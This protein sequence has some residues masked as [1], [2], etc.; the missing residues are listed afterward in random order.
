MANFFHTHTHSEFSCLDA[1]SSVDSLVARAKKYKQPAM[2][3]TDHGN[4]AG[5]VQLYRAGQKYG[6]PVFPG[7]EGYL[8]DD[9]LDK[10]AK[11]YHIGLLAPTFDAYQALS[12]LSSL[13]HTRE[14][15]Q[16]FPRFDLSDLAALSEAPG[17]KDLIVLTGCYFGMVQQTLVERGVKAAKRV[18]EMYA[19][20]FPNTFVEIQNHNIQHGL[21]SS[22]LKAL[23]ND[24]EICDAMVSIADEV[25]LPVIATQ[26]AHYC[27]SRDKSAHALMKRMVYMSKD[28]ESDNEFPGDS[29][30]FA[31][32][33]WMEEHHLADHWKKSEEGAQTMLDLWDLEFPALDT[34]KAQIPSRFKNPERVVRDGC[35]ERLYELESDGLL[36]KP[37]KK[38]E[39]RLDH[40]FDIIG[41]LKQW[42]YFTIWLPLVNFARQEGICIEA[43]GSSNGSLVNYLLGIT[44][45]D[46]LE[47]DLLFERFM[48]KDRKKPPDIDMDVED[49]A[50]EKIVQFLT[51]QYHA[52]QIGTF[53]DLGAREYDEET[54]KGD[55]KGSVLV[56]YNAYLRRK[57]GNDEFRMQFGR[58]IETI[59]DVVRV[60]VRDYK[61]LRQLAKSNVKRSYGVH[62]AGLLLDGNEVKIAD[63]VPTMLVASSGTSVTQFTMDDVE[64]LGFTKMDILGQRTLT[65]LRRCQE[66]IGRPDPTDFSWIPRDDPR[67][68]RTLREGRPENA[69]F[70][71]EGWSMAKGAKALG[72]RSTKDCILAGALFRPACMESG[73][74]D[75]YIERRR[76]RSLMKEVKYPHPVF[77]KVLKPTNG[78][79][80]F[81]EQV[82]EIM[83]GLGQS[84]EAINTFF[85]IV[86]D[87]GKGATERNKERAEE[88]HRTWSDICEKNGI[89]DPDAAWHFIEGYTKYGFNKAHAAGYG[90]RSY[91]AA[92]LKT[93]YPLEYMAAVLE[94]TAG[95]PK[96]AVYINEARRMGIRLM[97][98]DVNVSGPLWTLDAKR[99]AI[100]KGLASIKGVGRPAAEEIVRN[101]PYESVEEIIERCPPRLVTG[102][103][104]FKKTGEFNG[105]LAKLKEAGALVS[106][107]YGRS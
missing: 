87:S 68:A 15:F 61:G 11:R 96:E 60:N 8:V 49:I 56:T 71:F 33:E 29:F 65:T 73:V 69:I 36:V 64:E 83:R 32:T 90:I 94:T 21:E 45:I 107:G 18:V 24:R 78:V 91:R 54:G 105:V 4:I 47:D 89:T 25:G 51:D 104:M 31:S 102:G 44:S 80:L 26:D 2:G 9:T 19:R 38:Y 97:S 55:D 67:T 20:W 13:S 59:G 3:L 75:T 52:V 6:L 74:T 22:D 35:L 88:V 103:I 95:K 34:F 53:G 63:Y 98:P 16:R 48:S 72:I 27:W 62:A 57:M 50:R 30:H 46:P 1:I 37:V 41:Y 84:Y 42:G 100:R 85:K 81:Q 82:L 7:T 86:K 66:L 17:G 58:G 92:Y 43:R 106:L 99:G 93:H 28:G 23:W 12:N 5:T 70:Q 77:E 39:E 76:D 10:D 40:E 79:V 14:K 101:A